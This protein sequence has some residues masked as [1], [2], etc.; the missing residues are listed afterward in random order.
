MIRESRLDTAT[1]LYE[2]LVI[3]IWLVSKD[4]ISATNNESA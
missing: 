4:M 2:Q 1:L 3:V